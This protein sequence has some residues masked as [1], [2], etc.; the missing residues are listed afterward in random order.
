MS[1]LE[2][3]AWLVL[4]GTSMA[5]Q[6]AILVASLG[7]LNTHLYIQTALWYSNREQTLARRKKK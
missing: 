3:R 6:G 7:Y 4:Y 5:V 1:E 2:K